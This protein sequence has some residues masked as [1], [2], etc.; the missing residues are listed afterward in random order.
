MKWILV[1]SFIVLTIGYFVFNRLGE[2][3]VTAHD[4]GEDKNQISVN[5]AAKNIQKAKPARR[6]AEVNAV[7]KAE[8][9]NLGQALVEGVDY[10]EEIIEVR[11]PSEITEVYGEATYPGE[12]SQTDSKLPTPIETNEPAPTGHPLRWP[13]SF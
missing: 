6:P 12:I 8:Q 1:L 2:M 13:S 5:V 11:D 10:P 3:P 7:G 9:T 4:N